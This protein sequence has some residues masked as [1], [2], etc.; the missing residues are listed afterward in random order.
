MTISPIICV[1]II[2]QDN[3]EKP[4]S[5]TE[6]FLS[7]VSLSTIGT[8]LLCLVVQPIGVA[9]NFVWGGPN[10]A[11]SKLYKLYIYMIIDKYI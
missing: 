1:E 3:L 5:R 9:R 7:A 4:R 11:A 2:A 8:T 6:L 10:R